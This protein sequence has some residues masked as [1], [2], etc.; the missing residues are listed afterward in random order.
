MRIKISPSKRC[1]LTVLNSRSFHDRQDLVMML[2]SAGA[3][4]NCIH[5][6]RRMQTTA[7]QTLLERKPELGIIQAFLDHRA[8]PNVSCHTSA[9][10]RRA[11]GS[12]K[13]SPIHTLFGVH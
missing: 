6:L 4:P 11:G 1:L 2:L 5:E 13:W 9:S 12:W 8:D 10:G 3:N 7:F